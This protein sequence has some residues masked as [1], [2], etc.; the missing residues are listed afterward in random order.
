LETGFRRECH[1]AAS[2]LGMYGDAEGDPRPSVSWDTCRVSISDLAY[3]LHN[4]GLSQN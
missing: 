1:G 2:L 3:N 4:D